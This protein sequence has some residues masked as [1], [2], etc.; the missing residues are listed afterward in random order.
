FIAEGATDAG[1]LHAGGLCAVGR[2]MA[3][4]SALVRH[5]LTKALHAYAPGRPIVVVGDRDEERAGQA[6]GRD[7][8]L[9][10]A[11]H[12]TAALGTPV[13]SA[14]E[15][16]AWLDRPMQVSWARRGVTKDEFFAG[17]R[18]RLPD[19]AWATPYPH[20]PA[21]PEV[22]YL[23]QVPAANHN[24]ALDHLIDRFRPATE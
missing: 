16:L 1:A 4:A 17:L 8:A 10:L 20:F 3:R 21:L 18:Q 22:L 11:R 5:W 13:R 6:V 19:Y 23:G 24:G 15:L 7:G 2:P 14:A 12:L 9:A